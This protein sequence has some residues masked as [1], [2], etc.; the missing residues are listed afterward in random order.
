MFYLARCAVILKCDIDDFQ[1]NTWY[2]YPNDPKYKM[3]LKDDLCLEVICSCFEYK[4]E[5]LNCAKNMYAA[6]IYHLLK[7]D[8]TIASETCCCCYNCFNIHELGSYSEADEEKL[9]IYSPESH[10]HYTGFGVFEIPNS[11]ED[12]DKLYSF[13]VI[14]CTFSGNGNLLRKFN[15]QK[16]VFS[17]NSEVESL[18]YDLIKADR[19]SNLGLK[20]TI[21]CGLL[22][23]IAG[24]CIKQKKKDDDVISFIDEFITQTKKSSLDKNKS[25]QLI[26]YLRRGK[27]KSSGD[28][29]REVISKYAKP[30]YGGYK[31]NDIISKAYGIRST[32]SHGAC[33]PF[34]NS[35]VEQMKFILLDVIKGYMHEKEN[36]KCPN[37]QQQ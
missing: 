1:K 34:A 10:Y 28:I 14:S 9:F 15:P 2:K 8:Y 13:E 29:C 5:A 22:E 24:L 36:N 32:Y 23:H 19:A 16:Y 7:C 20:M 6:L 27:N 3:R 35:K 18:I 26:E 12:F 21:Y 33:A 37:N 17:Y 4:L 31:T 25:N 11:T 30:E